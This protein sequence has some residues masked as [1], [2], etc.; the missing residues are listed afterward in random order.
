[1]QELQQDS[2]INRIVSVLTF[3]TALLFALFTLFLFLF[4]L[5]YSH[6]LDEAHYKTQHILRIAENELT[7]LLMVSAAA[8]IVHLFD[9]KIHVSERALRIAAAVLLPVYG[10][11][12]IVW[13]LG[14][15]AVPMSDQGVILESVRL[16]IAGDIAPF[17]AMGSDIQFYFARFPFQF[18]FLAYAEGLVRVFGEGGYLRVAPVLNVCFLLAGDLAILK[19]TERV[20]S[21]HNVTFLTLCLMA[22][23]LQ[24]LF[25]ATLLY[26]TYP[27]FAPT[28]WACYLFVCYLKDR[29]RWRIAL[30][31]LLMALAV[32]LKSNAL[33]PVAAMG[34]LLLLDALKNRRLGSVLAAAVLI[35]AVLPLP[36]LTQTFY[37]NRTGADCKTGLPKVAWAA[38][39]SQNSVMA[40][41][42]YNTY[43]S[44]LY[45]DAGGDLT[46]CRER[47]T[48]KL[49]ENLSALSREDGALYAFYREKLLSQWNEN[50]FES[51]WTSR[52]CD[53]YGTVSPLNESVYTGALKKP[54]AFVMN[55]YVQFL[56]GGL[57]LFGISLLIRRR[58]LDRLLLPVLLL[59]AFLFHLIFEAKAQYV[60]TYVPLMAPLAS[61][62]YLRL[63]SKSRW[64]G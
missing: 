48:E 2:K 11:F 28:M 25:G 36:K 37:E 16:L 52:V 23:G 50:T 47:A 38:M 55:A 56:Y 34:I 15:K 54:T 24:P 44:H 33:I 20:F 32:L 21:D 9:R 63:V 26:G 45:L 58:P 61:C 4:S 27:A 39:S 17:S 40:P 6:Q 35:A 41:G 64:N 31:A 12:G 18:G 53:T 51:I 1:M 43:C 22:A 3:L 29:K 62:G 57:F 46:L 7:N 5:F 14:A 60:L 13:A 59:G 8:L 42:W 49:C 19:L 30:A 10:A